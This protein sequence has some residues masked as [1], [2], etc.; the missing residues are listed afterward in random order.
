MDWPTHLEQLQTVLC[1]F[2][3]DK[4]I[5]KPVLIRLFSDSIRPSIRAQAKQE[6]RQKD[7]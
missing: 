1:K 7:T 6:D 3:A 4:V 5:L 2:N